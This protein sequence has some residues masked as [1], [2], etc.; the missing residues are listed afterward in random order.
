MMPSLRGG[1]ISPSLD[2]YYPI[3]ILSAAD[4]QMI[5]EGTTSLS[6]RICVGIILSLLTCVQLLV[7]V[8]FIRNRT[9]EG[10]E[11]YRGN[12]NSSRS[13]LTIE[14]AQTVAMNILTSLSTLSIA[15]GKSRRITLGG[16]GKGI[17]RQIDTTQLL[18]V[19]VILMM[20]QLTLQILNVAI[21][22]MRATSTKRPIVPFIIG[23]VL[24]ALPFFLALLLN[25]SEGSSWQ[26]FQEYDMIKSSVLIAL[27]VLV[28]TIPSMLML[29]A[30]VEVPNLTA[31]LQTASLLA[32]MCYHEEI[33]LTRQR[34]HKCCRGGDD[35]G[36]DA[37]AYGK[38]AFH[39]TLSFFKLQGKYSIQDGFTRKEIQ[40]FS[41]KSLEVVVTAL[42]TMAK[43]IDTHSPR[44]FCTKPVLDALSIYDSAPV[45][46]HLKDRSFVF[47]VLSYICVGVQGGKI[48][49]FPEGQDQADYL[50]GVANTFVSETEYQCFHHCRALALKAASLAQQLKFDKAVEVINGMNR[51][52][53]P[54]KHSRI[55]AE[56][57]GS[58]HCCNAMALSALWLKHLGRE[59][60][61]IIMCDD[62]I[63]RCLPEIDERNMLGRIL[64]LIP[65][66]AV[67]LA[68]RQLERTVE[69]FTQ[70]VMEPVKRF[71]QNWSSPAKPVI[72]PMSLLLKICSQSEVFIT[73]L[74]DDIEWLLNDQEKMPDLVDTIYTSKAQW[75]PYDLYSEICLRIAKKL[76]KDDPRRAL[77]MTEGLRLSHL[78]DS[79]L[80]NESGD[81]VHPIAFS[82][83]NA[84]MS[85]LEELV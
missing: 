38:Y 76:E 8:Y 28:V 80:K 81:V 71:G 78:A 57:Y 25:T 42:V 29:P 40:S 54:V 62:V 44:E 60:E 41:A 15:C 7:A 36:K 68:Y 3:R 22:M 75:S 83:H 9:T 14:R 2:E 34:H 35:N 51:I 1:G 52:Y 73:E 61:A 55:I 82:I 50:L 27:T 19:T 32:R 11:S 43:T 13:K 72:R 59:Q 5:V 53:D 33:H 46:W 79:K 26:I 67:L 85:E 70:F 18:F 69:L 56:E 39:K 58:D 16:G 84:V 6:F 48:L 66:I 47:P 4:G 37:R 17:R 12:N 64:L 30:E 45:R 23:L 20:P 21:P 31:F 63:E 10:G 77:L 65:S 49:E 24:T 74:D